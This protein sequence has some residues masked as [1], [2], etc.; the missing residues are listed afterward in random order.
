MPPLVPAKLHGFLSILCFL[1]I[2]GISIEIDAG[3]RWQQAQL[4]DSRLLKLPFIS[5]NGI[6]R[7]VF[8][9]H[10]IPFSSFQEYSAWHANRPITMEYVSRL[11]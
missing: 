9:V 4:C 5:Y 1:S 7:Y 8:K 10:T 6:E 2:K 3:K 11:Y